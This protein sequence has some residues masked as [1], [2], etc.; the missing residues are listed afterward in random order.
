MAEQVHSGPDQLMAARIISV[1][2]YVSKFRCSTDTGNEWMWRM[3]WMA[4]TM[5]LS[6]VSYFI[7]QM[8]F[9]IA[10][11]MRQLCPSN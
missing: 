2:R 6:P 4:A 5:E 7:V 10:I 1:E 3:S 8:L 11:F 9:I